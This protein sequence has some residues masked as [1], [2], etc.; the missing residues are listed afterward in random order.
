MEIKKWE[1]PEMVSLNSKETK[2]ESNTKDWPHMWHCLGCGKKLYVPK[3]NCAN[4]NVICIGPCEEHP[5]FV[6][7]S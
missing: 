5:P 7:P 1:N 6:E 3:C 4:P 2:E